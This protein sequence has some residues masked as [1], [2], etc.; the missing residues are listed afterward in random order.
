MASFITLSGIDQAISDLNY[1]NANAL[2]SKMVHLIRQYYSDER[3]VDRLREIDTD[4]LVKALWE[5]DNQ[6]EVIRNRRKNLNSI[7][8]SVNA[9]LTR[10]Y[11]AGKNPEGILIGDNNVFTMS[12]EAKD[13]ALKAF[14]YEMKAD[15][16][17]SF[18]QMLNMLKRLSETL[19]DYITAEGKDTANDL[20]V[21]DQLKNLIQGLSQKIASSNSAPAGN[22]S[23]A[24]DAGSDAKMLEAETDLETV[25]E[26]EADD[27]LVDIEEAEAD[28][29]FE[30]V[31]A[32]A[33][34]QEIEETEAETDLEEIEETEPDEDLEEVESET[35]VEEIEEVE[36]EADPEE[37]D[38]AEDLDEDEVL[39]DIDAVASDEIA[40]PSGD[41]AEV[42]TGGGDDGQG[43]IEDDEGVVHS[44]AK[45]T[46]NERADGSRDAGAQGHRDGQG[47]LPEAVQG[48]SGNRAGAGF[49]EEAGVGE[50]IAADGLEGEDDLEK[51]E[52][53]E[54]DEDL[55]A[56]EDVESEAA[57]EEIEETEP[58]QGLEP[59]EAEAD[60]EE[61]D[62]TEVID[63]DDDLEAVEEV[64]ADEDLEEVEEDGLEEAVEIGTD[65]DLEEVEP[66][67]DVEEIE[68]VEAE[69]DPEEIEQAE[70]LDE[71]ELLE[72]IDEPDL[73]PVEEAEEV[74][75]PV[76]SLGQEYP[77]EV[78]TQIK[79]AR[80]LAEEFDGYLGA[81]DRYFNHIYIS[82]RAI[83][84]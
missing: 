64:E 34:T 27:D 50:D 52:E 16:T 77:P 79:D 4:D 19:P 58:D 30:A 2:K 26:S 40:E 11:D 69:A 68:E 62:E 3:S 1:R 36:A 17:P 42:A 31:E 46:K 9:E 73:E 14:G 81:M 20:G 70:D 56:V 84:K 53:I 80:L 7:K 47:G 49:D 61:I 45:A 54:T 51:A 63:E 10:L 71:D 39:E 8:S 18:S 22:G 74:G 5:T 75:L 28:D 38:E 60:P 32:E 59:V 43:Q 23:E 25:E 76:D 24:F 6:P 55:E 57:L 33:D 41:L 66:E 83:T 21:V 37:I 78:E 65:E 12:D 29:D 82:R 67:A 13:K 15:G 44:G 35:D 48:D 72:D